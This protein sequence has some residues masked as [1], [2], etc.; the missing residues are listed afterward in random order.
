M[1]EPLFATPLTRAEVEAIMRV[2]VEAV[3]TGDI[4]LNMAPEEP[5]ILSD[6][7]VERVRLAQF[8]MEVCDEGI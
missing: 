8:V 3:A 1:T 6:A 2:I 5:I 4:F 7:N